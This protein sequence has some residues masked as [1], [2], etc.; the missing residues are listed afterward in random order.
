MLHKIL[1]YKAQLLAVI[2]FRQFRAAKM[3][4]CPP[5]E[6][7][8][9][10]AV[11]AHSLRYQK[12]L[13]LLLIVLFLPSVIKAVDPFSF[14]RQEAMLNISLYSTVDLLGHLYSG[15][16]IDPLEE[17]QVASLSKSDIPFIDRWSSRK[18]DSGYDDL[19]SYLAAATLLPP[20]YYA[21]ID[22]FYGWDNLIVASEV[23]AA[24]LALASWTKYLT[25]RTRPYL[26]HHNSETEKSVSSR[27]S[28]YS[29]HTSTAFSMAVFNHYYQHHA[30][31][32][33][34]TNIWLGYLL[35]AG[36][37]G[38]RV[39]A[40][41]HFFSDVLVGAAAG[42][43]VSYYICNMRSNSNISRVYINDEYIGLSWLLH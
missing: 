39:A 13:S 2:S 25:L 27:F 24:Q 42:S 5:T 7:L 43:A 20:L 1:K 9:S 15:S 32:R 18:Y 31:Y 34:D 36:V 22:G 17:E 10:A 12:F 28:F 40:G 33:D 16:Y 30:S 23:L 6:T 38:S 11:F 19:S 29:A 4:K 21:G 41:K 26:Y 14:D 37:A 35:A 8:F 3:K